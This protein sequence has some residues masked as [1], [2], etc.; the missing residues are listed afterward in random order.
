MLTDWKFFR[1]GRIAVDFV[2]TYA[3]ANI[4]HTSQ[5]ELLQIDKIIDSL[6]PEIRNEKELVALAE[7]SL[8]LRQNT[9]REAIF[10]R[11][12]KKINEAVSAMESVSVGWNLNTKVLPAL[13]A[14]HSVLDGILVDTFSDSTNPAPIPLKSE[15]TA[16]LHAG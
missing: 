1:N 14:V 11:E 4:F 6:L 8:S 13:T 16:S 5:V 7:F 9:I 12:L 2:E 10:S 15:E 3:G